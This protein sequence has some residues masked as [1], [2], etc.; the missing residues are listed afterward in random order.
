M[1]VEE[2]RHMIKDLDDDM[3][4]GFEIERA[5]KSTGEGYNYPWEYIPL[6]YSCYDVGHSNNVLKITLKD[7]E[8]QDQEQTEEEPTTE[9][10]RRDV[11]GVGY[12]IAESRLDPHCSSFVLSGYLNGID[13]PVY[14]CSVSFFDPADLDIAVETVVRQVKEAHERIVKF[15]AFERGTNSYLK[16][17]KFK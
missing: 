7:D 12:I 13:V 9:S 15:R 2:L 1:K 17:L 3:E 5:T 11:D 6:K 10:L 4:V 16:K 14:G 8:E